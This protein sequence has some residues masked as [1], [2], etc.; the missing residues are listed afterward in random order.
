[1]FCSEW[2]KQN[3]NAAKPEKLTTRNAEGAVG[4]NIGLSV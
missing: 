3:V 2:G 1:M 4:M